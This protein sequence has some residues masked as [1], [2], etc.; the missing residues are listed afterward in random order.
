MASKKKTEKYIEEMVGLHQNAFVFIRKIVDILSEVTSTLKIMTFV[1]WLLI[2]KIFL[3]EPVNSLL[4]LT[5]KKWSTMSNYSKDLIIG[6]IVLVIGGIIV[7]ILGT[8]LMRKID[9]LLNKK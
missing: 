5:S 9:K 3:S 2:W 1:I 8:L 7:H 4:V 6:I